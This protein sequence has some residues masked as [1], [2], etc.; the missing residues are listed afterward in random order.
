M[1]GIAPQAPRG[2]VGFNLKT[3]FFTAMCFL[4]LNSTFN[5]ETSSLWIHWSILSVIILFVFVNNNK[6]KKTKQVVVVGK[7]SKQIKKKQEFKS[8]PVSLIS[9]CHEDCLVF[10]FQFK[11][12]LKL[13]QSS[14]WFCSIV[15]SLWQK[16]GAGKPTVGNSEMPTRQ[17]LMPWLKKKYSIFFFFKSLLLLLC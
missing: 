4:P 16:T 15:P 1:W 8:N 2:W 5:A 11:M 10:P 12:N 6:K 7:T 13:I 14:S 17:S 9:H 3:S